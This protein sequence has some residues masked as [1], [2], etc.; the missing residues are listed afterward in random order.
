MNV[1]LIMDLEI[2]N[3]AIFTE[4]IRKMPKIV[5][6]YRGRDVV[7]G[8]EP[9][10]LE[11]D[12]EPARIVVTEFPS[13]DDAESFLNDPEA[14]ALFKIRESSTTSKLMLVDG[15]LSTDPV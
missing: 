12:W 4:Y 13:R 11:G 3:I 8:V 9:R 10:I 7:Q 15:C 1:Y 14:I 2:H 6:K 5:A